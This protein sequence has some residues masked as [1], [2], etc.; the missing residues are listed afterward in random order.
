MRG[1]ELLSF[2]LFL[3]QIPSSSAAQ[4]HGWASGIPNMCYA[5]AKAAKAK[6]T[7]SPPLRTHLELHRP[8]PHFLQCLPVLKEV[9]KQSVFKF[10]S[11]SRSS[12]SH[13]VPLMSCRHCY[14]NSKHTPG[15]NP[16]SFWRELGPVK[17]KLN[18]CGFHPKFLFVI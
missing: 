2:C 17:S 6:R 1:Q 14:H 5:G 3:L 16:E 12:F 7:F 10:C 15:S 9:G 11:N 13:S 18:S 4:Q 8:T